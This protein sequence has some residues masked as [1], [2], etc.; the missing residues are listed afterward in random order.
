MS[1]ESAQVVGAGAGLRLGLLV[2]FHT[3]G[4]VVAAAARPI[5]S[6]EEMRELD[7]LHDIACFASEASVEAGM[8]KLFIGAVVGHVIIDGGIISK[9]SRKLP[10]ALKGFNFTPSKTRESGRHSKN[11]LSAAPQ[12]RCA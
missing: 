2:R 3:A 4:L 1:T 9:R 5:E 8:E 7:G 12:P 6:L 10:E 11:L